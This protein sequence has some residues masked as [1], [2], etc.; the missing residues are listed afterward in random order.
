MKNKMQ[1]LVALLGVASVFVGASLNAQSFQIYLESGQLIQD[2]LSS[3]V[4]EFGGEFNAFFATVA[5]DYALP[6]VDPANPLLD[7]VAPLV[8]LIWTPMIDGAP[9]GA[10]FMTPTAPAAYEP[11]AVG[12]K[13]IVAIFNAAGP[14]DLA[15]GSQIAV[16][17]GA[18]FL[19]NLDN[20]I[21]AITAGNLNVLVGTSGSVT[22]GTI[23]PE[24]STYAL[25]GGLLALGF[26]MWRRRRS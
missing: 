1:K 24:P 16:L 20:R 26:V 5:G 3:D 4:I 2:N 25:L 17:E 23:V 22:M 6:V 7:E 13:P 12:Q 18:E 14:G 9:A 8:S 21:M 11:I 19:S 10:T 15:P